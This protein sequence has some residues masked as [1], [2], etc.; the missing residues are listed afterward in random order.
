MED[1][2]SHFNLS[3]NNLRTHDNST[4]RRIQAKNTKIYINAYFNYPVNYFVNK[5]KLFL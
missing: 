3:F 1:L 5:T 2:Q 4:W